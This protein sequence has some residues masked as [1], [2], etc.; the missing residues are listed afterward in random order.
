MFNS[1][2]NYTT[3]TINL[4]LLITCCILGCKKNPPATYKFPKDGLAYIQLTTGKY[5]IYKD[6]AT[7]KTDSVVVT[8]SLL[9]TVNGTASSFIGSYQYVG[10]EYFLILSK[11][12]SGR[13][14]EWLNGKAEALSGVG[15]HIYLIPQGPNASGYFFRYPPCNCLGEVNIPVMIVEGK[16]YSNV[17]L[18]TYGPQ[19]SIYLPYY[20]YYWAKGVG[21]IKRSETDTT[22][23]K[24]YTLLRNN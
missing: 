10:E 8:T 9:Q 22:G 23:T 12:D 17:V 5:F 7:L 16:T 20:S 3:I 24:T 1:K 2:C 15:V 4:L 14:T 11:V 19:N 18:T 6:S 21:L 13:I